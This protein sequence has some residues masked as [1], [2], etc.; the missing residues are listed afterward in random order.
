MPGVVAAA[1]VM[2]STEPK[3]LVGFIEPGNADTSLATL[4]CR[5][6]LPAFMVPARVVALDSLPR[7][8]NGKLHLRQLTSQAQS[9]E[10]PGNGG[11]TAGETTA[12]AAQIAK[13]GSLEEFL[14]SGDATQLAESGVD[15]MGLVRLFNKGP[16]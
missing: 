7:L 15:S 6:K 1:V 16:R 10:L 14:K 8:P 3:A 2:K 5:S 12:L 9:V 13:F 11:G 4:H